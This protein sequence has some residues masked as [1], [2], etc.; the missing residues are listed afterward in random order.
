MNFQKLSNNL[1]RTEKALLKRTC[2]TRMRI[3]W[4]TCCWVNRMNGTHARIAHRSTQS[5]PICFDFNGKIIIQAKWS[6]QVLFDLTSTCSISHLGL[7][8]YCFITLLIIFFFLWNTCLPLQTSVDATSALPST[9]AS[10]VLLWSVCIV[11]CH[12]RP[13]VGC[14]FQILPIR[15]MLR[16]VLMAC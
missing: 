16:A 9:P 5:Y 2:T 14:A 11:L 15:L 1:Q 7:E 3:C 8:T 13:E 4:P 12:L 6:R 10:I